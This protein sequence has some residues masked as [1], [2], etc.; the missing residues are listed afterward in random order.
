M[1]FLAQKSIT[2]MEH[3]FYSPDLAP[4]DFWL[5]P[6]IKSALEGRTL[7]DT[8]DIQKDVMV[9]LKAV[10]QKEFKKCFQQ[11]QQSWAKCVATQGEYF[12]GDPLSVSCKYTGKVGRKS[13]RELYR[14]IS[15][16]SLS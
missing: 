4:Y 8:E 2:E 11:W 14:R 7:H 15:S 5:F 1:Q 10:P 9:A 16:A 12:K 6:K 13:F 3:P